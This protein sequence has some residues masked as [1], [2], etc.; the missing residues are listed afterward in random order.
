MHSEAVEVKILNVL[1]WLQPLFS[2]LVQPMLFL[3][4]FLA[5]LWSSSAF[6][7]CDIQVHLN[8]RIELSLI[9][10]K[11]TLAIPRKSY[12]ESC[13]P[14]IARDSL[15]GSD[16]LT[17]FGLN[18]TQTWSC[19]SPHKQTHQEWVYMDHLLYIDIYR[20]LS[21]Y[22]YVYIHTHPPISCCLATQYR[23]NWMKALS[24][25]KQNCC[26]RQ[27]AQQ[28]WRFSHVIQIT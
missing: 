4:Y 18:S 8:S 23:A 28:L 11:A 27:A 25:K 16:K 17:T 7:S 22:F 9:R 21:I 1:T 20:Y 15:L 5:F 6:L 24:K 14:Q 19:D 12:P 2:L 10:N 13:P 3:S 26:F